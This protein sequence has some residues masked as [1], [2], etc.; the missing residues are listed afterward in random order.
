MQSGLRQRVSFTSVGWG[1]LLAGVPAC[2]HVYRLYYIYRSFLI[3]CQYTPMYISGYHESMSHERS[4]SI[5]SAIQH[6]HAATVIGSPEAKR[7][8][9]RFMDVEIHG[10]IPGT[11]VIHVRSIAAYTSKDRFYPVTF[12]AANI[13]KILSLSGRMHALSENP[14][15]APTENL[16]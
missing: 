5:H 13:K 1:I 16:L 8:K 12:T 11:D 6:I 4:N 15:N 10:Q 7:Q 2:M 9:S 14:K 3:Q